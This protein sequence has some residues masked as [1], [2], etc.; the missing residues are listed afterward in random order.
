M[1][2]CTLS[3]S[4][5]RRISCCNGKFGFL[6]SFFSLPK[7]FSKE[8]AETLSR[9]PNFVASLL[10]WTKAS[11]FYDVLSLA[12]SLLKCSTNNTSSSWLK[13]LYCKYN[14]GF[15]NISYGKSSSRLEGTVGDA[16]SVANGVTHGAVE[17]DD[18][19]AGGQG[20]A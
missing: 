5:S 6:G 8:K 20:R 17:G 14:T 18:C 10:R 3:S 16:I 12:Y 15:I 4:C 2:L 1:L 9:T 7:T 19:C 11:T 13:S